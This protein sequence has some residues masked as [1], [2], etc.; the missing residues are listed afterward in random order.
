MIVEDEMIVSKSLENRLM[1]AGFN[2]IAAVNT[3]EEAIQKCESFTPDCI[4]M[5]IKLSGELDGVQTAA[6]IKSKK[7]IPV[8]YLTAFAD[9]EI[10]EKAKLT[11]PFGYLL[12]PFDIRDLKKTIEIALYKHN[13]E[14]KLRQSEEKFRI[15]FNH[16]PLGNVLFDQ[17]G[18]IADVNPAFV[19]MIGYSKEQ[20]IDKSLWKI[21]YGKEKI[22]NK[23]SLINNQ[24]I[25]TH[26]NR[27]DG[28]K[29]WLKIS[30][31]SIDLPQAAINY[32]LGVAEDVTVQKLSEKILKESEFKLRRM[33][34]NLPAGAVYL[35][36]KSFYFNR[37]VEKI[38][39]YKAN[40]ISDLSQWFKKLFPGQTNQALN[41]YN[42]DKLDK[43]NLTR[44]I[45]ITRKDNEKRKLE[46]IAH[47]F[48]SGEVWIL[49]DI[50]QKVKAEEKL[51]KSRDQLK[52]LSE[53][54]QAAREEERAKIAR[55]V[56]DDL[57]QSLTA[58]KMDIVWLKKNRLVKAELVSEKLD[59][60]VDVINQTIKTIQ[61]IGTELRPKLLDD[62]GLIS[63]IEWQAREFQKRSGIK[64]KINLNDDFTDLNN[65]ASLTLFRI[66]QEA[67]TN[68]ARHSK[69]DSVDVTIKSDDKDFYLSIYDNGVGI[70]KNKLEA[71]TSIGIIGMKERAEIV[72]GNVQIK[73]DSKKGTEII[74]VI[75]IQ[76]NT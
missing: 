41:Y 31:S 36:D 61:R 17:E 9:D 28:Q 30:F 62:L 48:S 45:E 6:I 58:L 56:H 27:L 71:S 59:S 53:H 19:K 26:I 69:A 23:D 76:E 32:F 49:N 25:E 8:I 46:F 39:G 7:N 47:L 35:D 11:D 63:A 3:G 70:P 66:F 29:T 20:L 38:T 74:V 75:P 18:K 2:V 68:I 5:D 60:M 72:G 21:L 34:E 52:K 40:E 33:V 10:L 51:I 65:N 22:F 67:L 15:L 14:I 44:I 4:L 50:T 12:K 55:E 13:L 73:T 57:G 42:N 1:N 54:L 64:C 43:F 24:S 16:S 37:E